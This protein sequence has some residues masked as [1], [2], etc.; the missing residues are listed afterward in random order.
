MNVQAELDAL[1][2]DNER[3][4][5]EISGLKISHTSLQDELGNHH[6][7]TT[8]LTKSVQEHEEYKQLYLTAQR[9]IHEFKNQITLLEADK[10]KLQDVAQDLERH[11]KRHRLQP[12]LFLSFSFLFTLSC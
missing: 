12:Y 6:N 11:S 4:V 5:E 3:H 10:Q 8:S 9:N 1:R 2:R 7:L